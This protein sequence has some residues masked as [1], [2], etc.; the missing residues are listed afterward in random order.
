M[1]NGLMQASES[2]QH[3]LAH[4]SSH[5]HAPGSPAAVV[6]PPR[7]EPASE[8]LVK[9][10]ASCIIAAAVVT[11]LYLARPILLPFALATL[12]AFALAPIVGVLQTWRLARGPAVVC[13]VALA[14]AIVVCLAMFIGTQLSHLAPGVPR[15]QATLLSKIESI[16]SSAARSDLLKSATGV[17]DRFDSAISGDAPPPVAPAPGASGVVNPDRP[18]LVTI[19]QPD[20]GPFQILENVADPMLMPL[21]NGALVVIFV[22]FILLQKE[23]LRDRFISLAGARDLQR[24]T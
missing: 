23:D 17:F 12:F 15:Y 16:K 13:A 6:V 24:T 7:L 18:V 19:R 9:I 2:P 4:A 1:G 21:A 5:V 14:V 8:H 20:P 22:I 3:L 10:A 11:T